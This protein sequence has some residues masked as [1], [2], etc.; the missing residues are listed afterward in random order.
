APPAA[1]APRPAGRSNLAAGLI[2]ALVVFVVGGL[3]L[4]IVGVGVGAWLYHQQQ[5]VAL[6]SPPSSPDAALAA[7]AGDLDPTASPDPPAA[8]PAAADPPAA[9]PAAAEPAAAVD[10]EIVADDEL[11]QWVAVED[12]AGARQFKGSPGGTAHLPPGSY[13]LVAKVRARGA[14]QQAW[15]LEGPTRLT[16]VTAAQGAVRCTP[17][18]GRPLD[19]VP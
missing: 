1:V 3:L 7:A 11:L 4:T 15:D 19:L 2:A 8:E 12:P 16:C 9:E 17:D 6:P 14:V 13:T 18:T 10:V 5:P